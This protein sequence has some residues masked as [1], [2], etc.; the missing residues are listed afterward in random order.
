M[1][2][3]IFDVVLAWGSVL[4]ALGWVIASPV[5]VMLLVCVRD[6]GAGRRANR[7]VLW[8]Q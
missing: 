4:C 5:I 7:R 3:T 1:R 6:N 2:L 8:P